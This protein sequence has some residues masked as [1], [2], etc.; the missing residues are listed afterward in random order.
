[1][2]LISEHIW[3]VRCQLLIEVLNNV[4]L[5]ALH[6]HACVRVRVQSIII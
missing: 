1:M 6:V 2:R 3:V 5:C 4:L